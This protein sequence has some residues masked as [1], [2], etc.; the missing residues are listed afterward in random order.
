ML[1]IYITEAEGH[2]HT[3]TICVNLSLLNVINS[4]YKITYVLC[5]VHT[6][7]FVCNAQW[8]EHHLFQSQF[9]LGNG[10]MK[11]DLVS[12]LV[13][14]PMLQRRLNCMELRSMDFSLLRGTVE[15]LLQTFLA[16]T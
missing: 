7:Y 1:K 11:T 4:Y 15:E 9:F 12:I 10:K 14:Q 6:L 3:Y 13:T 8:S 16:S 2:G 5:I